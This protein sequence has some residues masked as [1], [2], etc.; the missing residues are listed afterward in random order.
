MYNWQRTDIL[1]M[2]RLRTC[3]VGCER[4]RT[5]QNFRVW[6]AQ[7]K[8][9]TWNRAKLNTEMPW[10]TDQETEERIDH[11]YESGRRNWIT[12]ATGS[13]NAPEKWINFPFSAL[14]LLDCFF[15]ENASESIRRHD[16]RKNLHWK[17]WKN[18]LKK[19]W[20]FWKS[21]WNFSLERI[22]TALRPHVNTLNT[23]PTQ[24]ATMCRI[25]HHCTLQEGNSKV[26]SFKFGWTVQCTVD[27]QCGNFFLKENTTV[28]LTNFFAPNL[29]ASFSRQCTTESCNKPP[30]L[31][32]HHTHFK[33]Y[34]YDR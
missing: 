11:E 29:R 5:N 15:L 2:I 25:F 16:E 30:I 14:H 22:Q 31:N 28:R 10:F 34:G 26:S 24:T 23:E 12:N 17:F 33:Q 32:F 27:Q 13:G 6:E 21:K 9:F 4:R 7:K 1:P 20:N 18:Q 19:K 8:C 3:W